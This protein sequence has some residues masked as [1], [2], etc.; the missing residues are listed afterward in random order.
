MGGAGGGVL[1]GDMQPKRKGKSR[2]TM[3]TNQDV[4]QS[5]F[6]FQK[7]VD[8]EDRVPSFRFGTRNEPKSAANINES[9]P[10]NIFNKTMN[11]T[12][13]KEFS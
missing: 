6:Y 11:G 7:N 13:Q 4:P 10:K 3:K 9:S 8:E 2:E 12:P 5:A 1:N